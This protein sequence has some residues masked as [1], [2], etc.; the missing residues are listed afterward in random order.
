M[1]KKFIWAFILLMIFAGGG[2]YFWNVS[3]PKLVLSYILNSYPEKPWLDEWLKKNITIVAFDEKT[4]KELGGD[5]PEIFRKNLIRLLPIVGAASPRAIMIDVWFAASTVHDQELQKVLDQTVPS[6]VWAYVDK[7]SVFTRKSPTTQ[8]Q[9]PLG[10]VSIVYST[11]DGKKIMLVEPCK[12]NEKGE[13]TP[14]LSFLA[15]EASIKILSQSDNC[16]AWIRGRN[17]N[18]SFEGNDDY[19]KFSTNYAAIQK[20]EDQ[21]GKSY[22]P[23]RFMGKEDF[24]ER[25]SFADVLNDQAAAKEKLSDKIILIGNTTRNDR[26]PTEVGDMD[27]IE[28]HANILSTIMHYTVDKK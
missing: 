4:K 8:N 15:Y 9:L 27:G 10:H 2:L 28:I 22:I 25:I 16:D 21:N 19:L 26:Y 11:I 3:R 6:T 20:I 18:I 13:P 5:N 23:I 7:P 24:F 14:A 12:L 1:K 17:V